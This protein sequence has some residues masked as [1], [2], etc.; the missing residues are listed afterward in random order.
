MTIDQIKA[1][2]KKRICD[3][4]WRMSHLYF[5]T[6]ENGEKVIFKPNAVQ[7]HLFSTWHNRNVILK[8]RQHGITTAIDLYYL[9]ECLFNPHIEA[10]II[11]H[12]KEDATKIFRRKVEFPYN[13]LP[14]WIKQQRSLKTDSKTEM[15]FSNDSTIFVD[16]SARSQTLKY[17]HVSEFG[18]VCAKYPEKAEEIVTG[19]LNA[20]PIDGMVNIEST[21]EGQ[22]GAFYDICQTAEGMKQREEPLTKMDYRFYFFGW[23]ENP[24]DRLSEE[25]TQRTVIPSEMEEYFQLLL[26]K[27]VE[28]DDNQKAFYVKKKVTQRDKMTQE[29]PSTPDEAFKSAVEGAYYSSQM[30]KI[31]ENKQ[32]ITVSYDQSLPVNVGWDL[33]INDDMALVF[34]QQHRGEHRIIDFYQDN[35]E[36]LAYYVRMLRETGYIFGT[37]YLPHDIAVRDLGSG[38]SRLE[39]LQGLM[40]SEKIKIVPRIESIN[41][42]IEQVRNFLPSCWF[43]EKRTNQLLIALD[44]YRKEWDS[45]S[46]GFRNRPLHSPASNPADAFRT[47]CIGLKT[48]PATRS[49]GMVAYQPT[50]MG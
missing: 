13:N 50:R 46:G 38:I 43:D 47:L 29:F 41:D 24:N 22:E 9:D 49:G 16:T 33:G 48:M 31:R 7:T 30:R 6:D 26:D 45:K 1:E 34:H 15:I 21:A 35:N 27:G 28:L 14:E 5:I 39:T 2:I 18:K 12:K 42:G 40:P 17:L 11:A 23:Q 3:K 37:H 4:E 32:I 19:A 36:G 44:S 10:G 8:S 25:D 20:V